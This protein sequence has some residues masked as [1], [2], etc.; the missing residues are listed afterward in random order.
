MKSLINLKHKVRFITATVL[1]LC[2]V[3]CTS[4]IA[5]AQGDS[6]KT[7]PEPV[8]STFRGPQ[9]INMST[10]EIIDGLGMNIQ[11]RFGQ[12]VNTYILYDFFGMDLSANI[13]LALS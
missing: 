4:Y 9:L 6:T 10:N 13:R 2:L 7:A 3:P 1:T 5:F 11:H 8:T 12:I